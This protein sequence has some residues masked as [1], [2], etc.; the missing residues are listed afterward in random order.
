MIIL[1]LLYVFFWCLFYHSELR[2]SRYFLIKLA[3]E[4]IINPN[5]LKEVA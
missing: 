2:Y 5:E 3:I 4:A 1:F